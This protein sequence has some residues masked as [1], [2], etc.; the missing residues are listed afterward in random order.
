MQITALSQALMIPFGVTRRQ[1]YA[2]VQDGKM[3]VRFGPMFDER[4]RVDNVE[5]VEVA[6][7]PRWAGVG[8]RTNLRGSIGLIGSYGNTVKLTLKEAQPV[9]LYL[10]P[11]TCKRIYIS[12]EDPEAFMAAIGHRPGVKKATKRAA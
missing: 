7:W 12:L 2:Q 1:A 5:A 6:K 10:F 11:A 8:L 3:H 9:H 4:I